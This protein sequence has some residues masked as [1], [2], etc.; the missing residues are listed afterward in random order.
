MFFKGLHQVG[1]NGFEAVQPQ[2]VEELSYTWI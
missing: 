1:E 2:E